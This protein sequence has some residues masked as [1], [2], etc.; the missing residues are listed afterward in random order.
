MYVCGEGEHARLALA[1][2]VGRVQLLAETPHGSREGCAASYWTCKRQLLLLLPP[3]PLCGPLSHTQLL[4]GSAVS[5][6]GWVTADEDA[7]ECSAFDLS[8]KA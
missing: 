6:L 8:Q 3:P 7:R 2:S 4:V 5:L 1:M